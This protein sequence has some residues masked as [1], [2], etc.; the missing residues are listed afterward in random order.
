MHHGPTC[1]PRANPQPAG[2]LGGVPLEV[3]HRQRT[4]A[5]EAHLAAQHVVQRR[6]LVQ[7]RRPQH[8]SERR[9]PCLVMV[10]VIVLPRPQG[11]HRA[12]LVQRERFA[13][14]A[15]VGLREE[16]GRAEPEPDAERNNERD[17]N[18]DDQPAQRHDDIEQ[19]LHHSARSPRAH[20][21]HPDRQCDPGNSRDRHRAHKPITTA[22]H[23]RRHQCVD[24]MAGHDGTIAGQTPRSGVAA[25]R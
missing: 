4:W 9:H 19:P 24:S 21:R 18:R 23:S 20:R 15:G 11:T 22:R 10:R 17:R 8:P 6:Q 16:H 5:D 25:E 14:V 3:A 12:E 13:V 7:A 1:D 2:L